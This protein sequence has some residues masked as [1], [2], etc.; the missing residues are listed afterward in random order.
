MRLIIIILL[1]ATKIYGQKPDGNKQWL[2]NDSAWV[3]ENFFTSKAK[4]ISI[5]KTQLLPCG[6]LYDWTI[7]KFKIV[8]V[9][10]KNIKV[11][12]TYTF[13]VPCSANINEIK[14]SKGKTY[15]LTGLI[16]FPDNDSTLSKL[17]SFKDGHPDWLRLD[18]IE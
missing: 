15:A 4:F 1:F 17:N 11:N 8:S 5:E 2:F 7:A 3:K 12:K 18:K 16:K 14:F 6:Y 13:Y 9:D 10:N